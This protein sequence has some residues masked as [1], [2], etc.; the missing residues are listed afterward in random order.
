MIPLI[1]KSKVPRDAGTVAGAAAGC[2]DASEATLPMTAAA[3][4]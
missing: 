4:S 2:W 3:M 1:V